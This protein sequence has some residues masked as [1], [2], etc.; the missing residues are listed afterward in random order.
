[1]EANDFIARNRANAAAATVVI[2][3]S[4]QK[5]KVLARQGQKP[6]LVLVSCADS[7]VVPE[8]IFNAGLG[9]ILMAR[10]AG[11]TVSDAEYATIHYG[12]L[13]L[14]IKDIAV[15]GHSGCGAVKAAVRGDTDPYLQPVLTSIRRGISQ[16]RIVSGTE[17]DVAGSF[18]MQVDEASRLNVIHQVNQLKEH[19][20]LR[21]M[22]EAGEVR[23]FGLYYYQENGIVQEL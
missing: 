14:G 9:E 19:E 23:I 6:S 20:V 18:E 5:R 22:V 3:C 21:P 15:L 13:G 11:N 10:N 2:D 12:V 1:M 8:V 16:G 4:E 7:R 17:L